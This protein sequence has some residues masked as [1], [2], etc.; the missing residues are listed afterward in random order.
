VINLESEL[1]TCGA[2]RRRDPLP[3]DPGRYPPP[4]TTG[5]LERDIRPHGL[6][7]DAEVSTDEGVDVPGELRLALLLNP[8]IDRVHGP[9]SPKPFHENEIG[10]RE[11]DFGT[12]PN[13]PF[14]DS[15]STVR[16]C[17][18]RAIARDRP[19]PYRRAYGSLH[20]SPVAVPTMRPAARASVSQ[21]VRRRAGGRS[22]RRTLSYVP[23]PPPGVRPEPS[24]RGG[25]AK[26][27]SVHAC[28]RSLVTRDR[29]RHVRLLEARDLVLREDKALRP[30]GVLDVFDLGRPH[31]RRRHRGLVQEPR[32]CDLGG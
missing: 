17:P 21:R 28:G 18:V 24:S 25:V 2:P 30:D 32:Q 7:E 29:V 6:L 1:N 4:T 3:P 10:T 23:D 5:H 13:S 31:D 8:G 9:S 20:R 15:L 14:H 27:W 26:S 19:A 11:G 12:I 16:S 22:S